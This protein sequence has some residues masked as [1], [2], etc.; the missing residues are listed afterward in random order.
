MH[1]RHPEHLCIGTLDITIIE[2]RRF[3]IVVLALELLLLQLLKYVL[4]GLIREDQ[5][6]LPATSNAATMT[7]L[8][9]DDGA[10][11]LLLPLGRVE[12]L[13]VLAHEVMTQLRIREPN[14]ILRLLS[15]QRRIVHSQLLLLREVLLQLL[16]LNLLD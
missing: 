13:R 3:W 10:H 7:R 5:V 15:I 16:G 1:V 14:I 9:R 8:I 4:L 6:R 12:G 11:Q 2:Y